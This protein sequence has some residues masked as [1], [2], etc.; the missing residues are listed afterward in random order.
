M[1]VYGTAACDRA[2]VSEIVARY[3]SGNVRLGRTARVG[4]HGGGE[5][6]AMNIALYRPAD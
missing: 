1:R 2:A 3:C 4:R 6:P 5:I